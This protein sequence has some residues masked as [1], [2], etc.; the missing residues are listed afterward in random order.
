VENGH[1]VEA[2]WLRKFQWAIEQQ[3]I[4]WLMDTL[5]KRK[6]GASPTASEP[7]SRGIFGG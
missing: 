2:S 5:L 4:G 1:L 3:G 6:I 7:H